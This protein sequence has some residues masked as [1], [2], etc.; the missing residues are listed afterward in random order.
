[1]FGAFH[2]AI[3]AGLL[4]SH[5]WLAVVSQGQRE[6]TF[7]TLRMIMDNFGL[8]FASLLI[9]FTIDFLCVNKLSCLFVLQNFGLNEH[10]SPITNT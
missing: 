1:M 6:K 2:R 8:Y 4:E 5:V 3:N 10:F 7:A 9:G